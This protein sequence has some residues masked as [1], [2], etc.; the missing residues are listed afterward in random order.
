MTSLSIRP[1]TE[2]HGA[3]F[4][5]L[6]H[7]G[8]RS[9]AS[10][11]IGM[12]GDTDLRPFLAMANI[13]IFPSKWL[14]TSEG[15]DRVVDMPKCRGTDIIHVRNAH[16]MAPLFGFPLAKALGAHC[17]VDFH[18][19][20]SILCS[21]TG[22]DEKRNRSEAILQCVVAEYADH[23]CFVSD[24]DN[25]TFQRQELNTKIEVSHVPAFLALQ[26]M[27]KGELAYCNALFMGNLDY[28][29]NLNAAKYIIEV[30]SP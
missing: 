23:C 21:M 8:D 29:P 7:L 12:R 28:P 24:A 27:V 20:N 5:W 22:H 19:I 13:T 2:S 4:H 30:L 17:V 3:F 26:N 9:G 16:T 25:E 18:D 14:Y 11:F 6:R 1:R 15:F 10:F